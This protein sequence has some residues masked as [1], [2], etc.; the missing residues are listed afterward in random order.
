MFG[1]ATTQAATHQMVKHYQDSGGQ[2]RVTAGADL[3]KSQAY[4]RAFAE[5]VANL[6]EMH[7]DEIQRNRHGL[8][9]KVSQAQTIPTHTPKLPCPPVVVMK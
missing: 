7:H 1:K 6:I 8:I 5:A 2:W 4:P 3:K 9:D